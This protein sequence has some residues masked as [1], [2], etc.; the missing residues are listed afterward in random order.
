MLQIETKKTLVILSSA[1]STFMLETAW[2]AG[3]CVVLRFRA[4]DVFA[5][6]L[7]HVISQ[8]RQFLKTLTISRLIG[9]MMNELWTPIMNCWKVNSKWPGFRDKWREWLSWWQNN[10]MG[11]V[12]HSVM[13]WLYPGPWSALT[14]QRG[15]HKTSGWWAW[16][17]AAE[18]NSRRLSG[19]WWRGCLLDGWPL[20]T[21]SA[22]HS[23]PL[24]SS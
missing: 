22:H 20:N 5:L 24:R 1:T 3:V 9:N 21:T 19:H 18:R 7:Q 4:S 16:C 11:E 10:M 23:N 14:D 17:R 6:L 12:R 8:G 15:F 2:E 13:E